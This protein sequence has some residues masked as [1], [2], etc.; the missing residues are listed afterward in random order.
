MRHYW[1]LIVEAMQTVKW[2]MLIVTEECACV[3]PITLALITPPAWNQ[4][5]LVQS[6]WWLNS[7]RRKWLTAHA[8]KAFAVV[9]T[10]T[11]N[12]EN[13]LAYPLLRLVTFATVMNI[14]G[15]GI[16]KADANS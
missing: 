5:Y 14:V 4:L 3:S 11:Y 6:A 7:A 10:D 16:R 12:L 9:Q 1:V 13:T 2:P 8:W 15:Y